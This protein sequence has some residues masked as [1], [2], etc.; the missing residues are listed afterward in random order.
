MLGVEGVR[1]EM[2]IFDALQ[3]AYVDS[4]RS[5]HSVINT[6]PSVEKPLQY[7]SGEKSTTTTTT[8]TDAC[9]AV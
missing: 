4:C 8:R 2:S 5:T 6:C 7:G 1:L 3:Y 9:N